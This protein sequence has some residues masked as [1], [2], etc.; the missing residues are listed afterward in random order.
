VPVHPDVVPQPAAPAEPESDPSS[1]GWAS[2]AVVLVPTAGVFVMVAALAA[3]NV[4]N[5]TWVL[6]PVM[7]LALVTVV[8]VV[9]TI[10]RMLDDEDGTNHR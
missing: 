4:V 5:S 9:A 8:A 7:L 10:M 6:V 3:A 2:L 1:Y